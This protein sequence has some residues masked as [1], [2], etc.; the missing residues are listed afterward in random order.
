MFIRA[1]GFVAAGAAAAIDGGIAFDLLEERSSAVRNTARDD[2][3][4]AAFADRGAI[5]PVLIDAARSEVAQACRDVAA[6]GAEEAARE[7][8]RGGGGVHI[9]NYRSFRLVRCSR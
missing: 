5:L 3:Q 8:G 4:G 7:T 6:G 2:S 9:K 1:A